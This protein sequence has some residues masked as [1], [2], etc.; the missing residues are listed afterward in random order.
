MK[1]EDLLLKIIAA[2]EGESV[3]PAQLQKV[4]FLL[5][6]EFGDRLPDNYYIFQKYDYGPFCVE[7]YRDAEQL[8]R[9]GLVSIVVNSSGGW[10]EYAATYQGV[11][12]KHG[13]IPDEIAS[14]INEKVEWARSLT[15]QQLVRE[16]YREFPE[17]R[18]NSVFQH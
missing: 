13:A 8:Q 15:F 5:G 1:R 9:E 18:E 10:K 4:A 7:V 12:K 14:Y 16:V 6:N 2:A 11:V 17:Y 3:T